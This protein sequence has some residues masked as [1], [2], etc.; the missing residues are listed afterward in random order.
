ME[1][2]I[3][4]TNE[5]K[6]EI[7]A[8]I[9]LDTEMK[10]SLLAAFIRVNGTIK[11]KNKNEYLILRTE[12]AKVAK[13]IYSLIKDLYEDVVVS[14]SFRKTM[15]FYKAT[16][17]LVNIING[18]TTIFSSLDI[19]LLESKINQELINK[20]DKIR[21]FL[22]GLFLACGS[23]NSPKTSNYHFE[24]YVSDENLAKN[25]L[26]IINKIKSSQFD[27]KLTKRRNNFV[28]Y[29]KKSDQ[30]SGFLAFLDAS[31]CCIKFEDVRVSRDYS[32]IN[33][34]LIICDQYN[35]KKSIDKA[36]VQIEQIKLIDKHLGIDNIINE[37]VQLLCKLRLKDPEASYADLSS[38]MSEELNIPVSK[39]NIGHLFRKIENMAKLYEKLK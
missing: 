5:I 7:T 35:Y 26:K 14:F 6:N 10:R 18:G 16:E 24:F 9:N 3:S 4:F 32:N 22:M 28:I 13:F 36:N 19:N 38:M 33:N 25:I 37:K 30:I 2:I 8:N 34:R 31:T 39:S 17:Y 15:K 11:F 27:F 20:E 12:N 23:C 1:E 21:G 29:L